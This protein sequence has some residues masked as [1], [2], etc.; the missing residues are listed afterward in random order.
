MVFLHVGRSFTVPCP[1]LKCVHTVKYTQY[2][3]LR[4]MQHEN[5]TSAQQARNAMAIT[6]IPTGAAE[7]VSPAP[8]SW[9]YSPALSQ[10]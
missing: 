10:L 7:N 3:S 8:M 2:F 6:A 1:H 4:Q 5:I 9:P